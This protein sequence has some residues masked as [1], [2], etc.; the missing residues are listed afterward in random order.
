[1]GKAYEFLKKCGV[2][3]VLTVHDGKPAG[4]PFGAV[5]EHDGMLYFTTATMKNVYKQLIKNPEIQIIALMPGTR[6]W[7]RIDGKARECSDLMLKQKMLET[8][9]IL[10]KRFSSPACAYFALFAVTEMEAYLNTD[11]GS[12]K[13][14]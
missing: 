2:F 4:R 10:E 5:M 7:I 12:N 6:E 8:C 3:Y 14:R 11:A 1:M 9:P 13:I